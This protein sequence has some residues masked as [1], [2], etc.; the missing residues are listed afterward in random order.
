MGRLR[1]DSSRRALLA[2]VHVLLPKTARRG[3]S[4]VH[5]V[6]LQG[7]AYGLISLFPDPYGLV[8]ARCDNKATLVTCCQRPNFSM[9]AFELLYT[10]ELCNTRRQYQIEYSA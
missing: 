3:L 7:K 6:C 10:L 1:E 4:Q 9:V 2:R 8:A 5:A